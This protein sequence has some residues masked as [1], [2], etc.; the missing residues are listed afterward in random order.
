M[1]NIF[2]DTQWLDQKTDREI[3]A[4]IH[5]HT[6]LNNKYMFQNS[7]ERFRGHNRVPNFTKVLKNGAA[8]INQMV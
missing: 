5:I 6:Y 1:L 4:Y 8:D 2:L 3:D 7:C